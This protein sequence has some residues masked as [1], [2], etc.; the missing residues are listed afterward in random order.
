MRKYLPGVIEPSFGIGR[1]MYAILEHSYAVREKNGD[2]QGMLL[3]SPLIAPVKCSL[4]PL[5]GTPEF[6]EITGAL[7]KMFVN[8]N[9]TTKV[10]P[11]G[12]SIGRKYA[13]SDEIGIPFGITV[14][15]ESLT[16]RDVTIRDRDSTTQIRVAMKHAPGIVASLC[17]GRSTWDQ[18]YAKYTHFGGDN[19]K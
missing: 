11:S 8:L 19:N 6:F 13:R 9:L 15:F 17:N 10:D 1:I 18:M 2:K 14:D 16:K 5:G 4:L 7:E 3:L 12:A